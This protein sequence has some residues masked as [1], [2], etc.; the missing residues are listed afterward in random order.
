MGGGDDNDFDNFGGLTNNATPGATGNI[1][2]STTGATAQ[3][4]QAGNFWTYACI[5]ECAKVNPQY[6]L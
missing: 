4:A 3:T 6:A 2:F 5:V 1:L